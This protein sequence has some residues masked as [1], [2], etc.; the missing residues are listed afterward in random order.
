MKRTVSSLILFLLAAS[1]SHAADADH[2]MEPSKSYWALYPAGDAPA[3]CDQEDGAMVDVSCCKNAGFETDP[4]ADM[5]DGT[6][7][8]Y[9]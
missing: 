8:L 2:E 6:W 4:I 3:A 1:S 7:L 5:Y 9:H